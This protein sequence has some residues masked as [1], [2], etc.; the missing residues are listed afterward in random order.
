MAVRAIG[1]VDSLAADNGPD[2]QCNV[3]AVVFDTTPQAV[4]LT[5][6]GL[7]ANITTTPFETAIRDAIKTWMLA[8]GYT[9]GLLDSIKVLGVII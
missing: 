5:L 4:Q 2:W 6:T 9:F 8:Q 1:R 7:T 3:T